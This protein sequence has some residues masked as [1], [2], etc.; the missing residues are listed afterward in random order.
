VAIQGVGAVG[1][2]LADLLVGAGAELVIADVAPD[3]VHGVA[4]RTGAR[5]V[6]ADEILTVPCDVLSPCATGGVLNPTTIPAL[7]CRAI[8]GAAN[9]QLAS[10]DDAERLRARG[11]VYAP[12]FA[13]NAGGVIHLAGYETLGWD[14][15]QVAARLAGIEVTVAEILR[16]SVSGGATTAEAAA[17]LAASRITAGSSA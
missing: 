11:I 13:A 12:D 14:E 1:A 8:A 6:G 15:A 7:S 10:D 16:A 4:E 3:V 9:N 2:H 17:R 5:R